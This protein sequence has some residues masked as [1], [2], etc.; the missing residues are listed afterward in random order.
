MSSLVQYHITTKIGFKESNEYFTDQKILRIWT[1]FTQW[2]PV[3]FP[4][5][6]ASITHLYQ[7]KIL[8]V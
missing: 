5:I 2:D 4:I 8:D 1:L 3:N 6:S 7:W